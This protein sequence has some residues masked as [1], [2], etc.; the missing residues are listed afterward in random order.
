M[1]FYSFTPQDQ[2]SEEFRLLPGPF[3]SSVGLFSLWGWAGFGPGL[4]CQ[5]WQCGEGAGLPA[6]SER[7]PT[8]NPPT[9]PLPPSSASLSFSILFLCKKYLV[10]P[11]KH[12]LPSDVP[13]PQPGSH[14]IAE[15]AA[16]NE[17]GT[18]NLG[19]AS[20][21]WVASASL[22]KFTILSP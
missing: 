6:A 10:L 4:A 13:W 21:D 1:I 18:Q 16:S 11:W 9:A 15:K 12:H 14:I 20:Q 2:N 22:K 19:F 7:P 5:N 17:V 8:S 3:A